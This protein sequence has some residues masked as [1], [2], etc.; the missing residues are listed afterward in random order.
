MSVPAF[1]WRLF[2]ASLDPSTGSEQAGT[3][4][5]LVVSREVINQALPVVA[6]VPLTTLKPGRRVYSTEV[7]LPREPRGSP[8]LRSSSPTRSG[9]SRSIA[10]ARRTA[11]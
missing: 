7:L 2:R 4:P 3:R 8:T 1:Q 11:S 9:R 5:V 10:S 6:V